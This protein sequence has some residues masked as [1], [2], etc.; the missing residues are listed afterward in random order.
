MSPQS[1]HLVATA[2]FLFG[3][4]TDAVGRRATRAFEDIELSKASIVDF[5]FAPLLDEA[6]YSLLPN[7]RPGGK[8]SDRR[9][10]KAT[11]IQLAQA[12]ECVVQVTVVIVK[13]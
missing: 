1:A 3:V 10:A 11:Q 9:R 7:K 8:E 4:H 6:R 12:L 5:G 13:V 2:R